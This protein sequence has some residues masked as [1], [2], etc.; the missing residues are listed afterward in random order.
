M[1]AKS[2][3][4]KAVEDTSEEELLK[5]KHGMGMGANRAKVNEDKSESTPTEI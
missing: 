5:T 1:T 2:K 4:K 3:E